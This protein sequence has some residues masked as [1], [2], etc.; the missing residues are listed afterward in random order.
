[1]LDRITD[2]KIYLTRTSLGDKMLS[3]RMKIIWM[4]DVQ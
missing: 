1:M 4:P 2:D 3:I